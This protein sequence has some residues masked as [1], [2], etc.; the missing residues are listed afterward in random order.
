MCSVQ[1]MS[2]EREPK[3]RLEFILAVDC[4]TPLYKLGDTNS[5]DLD[6]MRFFRALSLSTHL[7]PLFP[8]ESREYAE[9]HFNSIF[10]WIDSRGV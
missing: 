6:F 3:I 10:N 8:D 2:R 4:S 9:S 1:S 7:A 5:F